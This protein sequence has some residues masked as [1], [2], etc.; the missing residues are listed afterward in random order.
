MGRK[1]AHMRQHGEDI[2]VKSQGDCSIQD[3]MN[4]QHEHEQIEYPPFENHRL[5]M[6]YGQLLFNVSFLVALLVEMQTPTIRRPIGALRKCELNKNTI[7]EHCDLARNALLWSLSKMS[8]EHEKRAI[9]EIHKALLEE[10]PASCCFGR[11]FC[12]A[13]KSSTFVLTC[14]NERSEMP[15]SRRV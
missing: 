4:H 12:D 11:G 2:K 7:A 6:A 8:L 10:R 5:L 3:D 13:E 1:A 14:Y 9:F 15:Q